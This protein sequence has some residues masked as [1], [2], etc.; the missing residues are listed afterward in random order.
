[1]GETTVSNLKTP[2]DPEAPQARPAIQVFAA[3]GTLPPR[4]ERMDIESAENPGPAAG[5]PLPGSR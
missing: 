3:R 1:M 5:G 4:R 2:G